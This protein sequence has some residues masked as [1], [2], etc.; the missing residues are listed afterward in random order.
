MFEREQLRA[1][2]LEGRV[3]EIKLR[4][5][6][7]A[8]KQTTGSQIMKPEIDP[9]LDPDNPDDFLQIITLDPEFRDILNSFRETVKQT[10][11][12]RMEQKF[13]M[14]P[15]SFEKELTDAELEEYLKD[16]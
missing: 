2:L 12:K 7:L 15:T 13:K 8:E 3:E 14:E 16:N 10:I 9:N 6:T 4:R 11:K 1:K 5:K